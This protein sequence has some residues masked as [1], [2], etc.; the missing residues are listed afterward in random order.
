MAFHGA[1]AV[2]AATARERVHNLWVALDT[3][4]EIAMAVGVVMAKRDLDR[5][6]AFG[7]LRAASQDA[8]RKLADIAAAVLGAGGAAVLAGLPEADGGRRRPSGR[9]AHPPRGQGK[10][11][12]GS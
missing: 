2:A 12:D 11:H 3:N 1:L 4:R 9:T 10:A 7:L 8:N 5:D 6:E